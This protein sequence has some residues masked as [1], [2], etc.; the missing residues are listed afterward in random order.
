MP[1][2]SA[3]GATRTNPARNG[4]ARTP[5]ARVASTLRPCRRRSMD[6][7][8]GVPRELAHACRNRL[9]CLDDALRQVAEL[10]LDLTDD[11]LD[12]LADLV[13][14]RVGACDGVAD[15]RLCLRAGGLGLIVER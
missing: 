7:S 11:G 12:A 2:P 13:A 6:R 9:H 10:R 5:P 15:L 14:Q 4:A 1:T 8:G 3:A